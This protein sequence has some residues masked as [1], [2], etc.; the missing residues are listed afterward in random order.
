MPGLGL[1]G[2]Q[3]GPRGFTFTVDHEIPYGLGYTLKEDDALHMARLRLD[4]V[5]ARLFGVP[6]DYLLRHYAFQLADHF[7]K[8]SKH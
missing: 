8:G 4:K 3:Q 6:F 5:R 7:T 1:G 2:R